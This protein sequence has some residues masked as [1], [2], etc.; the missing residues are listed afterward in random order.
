MFSGPSARAIQAALP[1]LDA[2]VGSALDWLECA[3]AR[4]RP[5]FSTSFGA[6]DMVLLDLIVCEALPIDVFTLDTGRLHE[7]THALMSEVELRYGRVFELCFPQAQAVHQLVALQGT[8]GFYRSVEAR[9]DCCAVRK[10]QPLERALAGRGAWVTGQR[11]GQSVTRS[12]LQALEPDDRLGLVKVNPLHDWSEAEVWAYLR[13]HAV[14]VNALHARGF[15]SIG[16]APC[17]RAVTAGED[18]RAGRWWWERADSRECGLHGRGPGA[19]Q[20]ASSIA[21]AHPPSRE[22]A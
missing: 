5:A 8:N 11:A 1:T 9:R 10:V 4:P 6:E 16:C 12:A 19:S 18:P 21:M 14:P 20:A 7:E 22:V 15:P 17:T 3:A 13:R 2:R